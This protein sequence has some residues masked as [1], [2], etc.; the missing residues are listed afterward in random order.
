MKTTEY[1]PEEMSARISRFADLKPMASQGNPKIPQEAADL[2][3]ARKLMPV[4][5][6]GELE[7]PFGTAAPISGAAGMSMIVAACPPNTGPGLHSHH[8]TYE[9]FTV[10]QG[11]FEVTWGDDGQH[12]VVLERLDTISVPPGVCRSFRNVGEGEGLLQVVITGGVHDA[13]DIAFPPSV[14]DKID[15][16][17]TGVLEEVEK[18]GLSFDAGSA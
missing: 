18:T 14:A 8:R 7:T 2:I 5:T 1:S 3:W 16:M 11:T 17:G 15:A 10:L 9:T 4:I 12:G 6:Y 13:N